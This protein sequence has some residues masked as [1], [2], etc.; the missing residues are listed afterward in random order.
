[1]SRSGVGLAPNVVPIFD[2]LKARKHKYI[3]YKL[4][5][6]NTT[7]EVEKTSSDS[8][9]EQFIADLPENDC[10]FAVYDIEYE[11]GDEGKR[12]K[13]CLITWSPDDAKVKSK[14]VYASSK[15]ALHR[16]LTGVAFVIQGS[17][18]SEVAHEVILEKV[19]KVKRT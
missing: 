11:L 4:N 12:S 18:Y 1:M 13:I 5:G 6:N 16:A 9:Y 19:S 2:E 10:R 3:I 14:M 17:D 7:I 15:D 8:N